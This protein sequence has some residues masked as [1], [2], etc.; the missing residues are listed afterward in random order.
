VSLGLLKNLSFSTTIKL[1]INPMDYAKSAIIFIKHST[2][3]IPSGDNCIK[4]F[5]LKIQKCGFFTKSSFEVKI[6][7]HLI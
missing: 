4:N 7:T 6:F 2:L 5:E 3:K 1:Q